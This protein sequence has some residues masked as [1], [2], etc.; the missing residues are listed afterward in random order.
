M[1]SSSAS[2]SFNFV[3]IGNLKT[4]K[5]GLFCDVIGLSS[6]H[7]ELIHLKRA[8][9]KDL[10]KRVVQLRDIGGDCVSLDIWGR[11]AEAFDGTN[12]PVIAVK[13]A[14]IVGVSD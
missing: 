14:K 13:C 9:G 10:V 5:P 8:D 12:N 2:N 4:L 11:T 7:S 1:N 6:K 3:N